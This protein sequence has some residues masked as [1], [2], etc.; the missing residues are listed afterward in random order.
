MEAIKQAYMQR[1]R[2]TLESRVSGETS[3]S[4]KKLMVALI[5]DTPKTDKHSKAKVG[6]F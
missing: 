3:G 2:K 1:Y 6:L 5:G 4:Y